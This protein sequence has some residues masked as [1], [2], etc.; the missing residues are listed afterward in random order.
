[1]TGSAKN[2]AQH[3]FDKVVE[4]MRAGKLGVQRLLALADGSLS[5]SY[6]Y[7]LAKSSYRKFSADNVT[8]MSAGIA[9]YA[10]FSLFPLVLGAIALFGVVV[11]SPELQD[12][13]ISSLADNLPVSRDVV[14]SNVRGLVSARGQLGVVAILGLLWSGT[15]VFSALR[16]AL[17]TVWSVSGRRPFLKQKLMDLGILAGVGLLLVFSVALT[18][19]L[20]LFVRIVDKAP[21]IAPYSA[22]LKIPLSLLPPLFNFSIFATVY[23]YVPYA[24]VSWREVWPGALV[25]ALLV[26]GGKHLFVWYVANQ[27]NY[28]RVYG[29]VATVVALMFWVYLSTV[30][31]LLGAEIA[32]VSG[33]LETTPSTHAAV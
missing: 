22:Y 30:V 33:H 10:L 8:G 16:R 21:G 14:S 12:R 1:M 7:L 3:G 2:Q 5:H 18:A 23:R 24:R 25:A 13:V 27:A 28:A 4:A 17:D 29:S 15:A 19:L 31:L 9:Y 6:P 20:Y 32:Y 26:E 11:R